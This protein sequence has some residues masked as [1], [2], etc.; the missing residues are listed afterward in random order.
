MNV[1]KD[2]TKTYSI[3]R[4]RSVFMFLKETKKN[5]F[6]IIKEREVEESITLN[7]NFIT[8]LG[9]GRSMWKLLL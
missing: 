6:I 5:I 4:A 8:K 3:N 9:F 1:M 7:A 2:L